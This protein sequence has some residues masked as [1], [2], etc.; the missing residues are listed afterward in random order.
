MYSK[1]KLKKWIIQILLCLIPILAVEGFSLSFLLPA[2]ELV[3]L[4]LLIPVAM[5]LYGFFSYN[6]LKQLIIPNALCCLFVFI[7]V[8]R[9]EEFGWIF[10]TE[11]NIFMILLLP[12]IYCIISLVSSFISLWINKTKKQEQEVQ[13]TDG[14]S[15]EETARAKSKPSKYITKPFIYFLL[16]LY[17]CIV[18]GIFFVINAVF[19]DT[20]NEIL[21]LIE[22]IYFVFV[23]PASMVIY[24]IFSYR[25]TR[26][27][28]FPNLLLY[29]GSTTIIS[30]ILRDIHL[31]VFILSMIITALSLIPSLITMFT[32]K[33]SQ[34]KLGNST[35]KD[36]DTNNSD[37]SSD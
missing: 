28:I 24:G 17:P 21:L 37:T 9:K 33:R 32:Y 11:E 14:I 7:G 26:S 2:G 25:L 23:I 3:Y 10:D 4:I 12:A 27:V 5:S 1:K 18:V 15:G 30:Y 29:I 8:L 20:K 6:L 36:Q 16:F 34:K 31:G 35:L 19:L 22:L 13:E